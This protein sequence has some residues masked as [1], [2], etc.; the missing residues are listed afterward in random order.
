VHLALWGA[1]RPEQLAPLEDVMGWSLDAAAQRDVDAIVATYVTHPIGPEFMA[2]P[3]RTAPAH[4]D[5]AR[6]VA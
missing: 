5:R 3:D 6:R 2:P 1:R 4:H